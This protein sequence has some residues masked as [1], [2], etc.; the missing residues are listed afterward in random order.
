MP[1]PRPCGR[2]GAP[3]LGGHCIDAKAARNRDARAAAEQVRRSPVCS[4]CGATGDLTAEHDVPVSR[5]GTAADGLRTL[6]R[7]CNSSAGPGGR[8]SL[9]H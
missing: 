3:S 4:C 6:C 1:L 5:G 8:C 7:R 2:C 9:S